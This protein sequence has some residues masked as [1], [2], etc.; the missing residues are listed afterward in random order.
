VNY[1]HAEA[2]HQ[3]QRHFGRNGEPSGWG[4]SGWQRRQSLDPQ[5]QD[6]EPQTSDRG[7]AN[8][9]ARGQNPEHGNTL[10]T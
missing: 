2:R 6:F 10:N 4:R 5:A 9:A 7:V 3:S 1:Y 8:P